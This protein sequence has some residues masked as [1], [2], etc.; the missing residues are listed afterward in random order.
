MAFAFLLPG[1]GLRRADVYKHPQ[2]QCVLEE[3]LHPVYQA[4]I[5]HGNQQGLELSN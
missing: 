5:N 4:R 3:L 2:P 1:I